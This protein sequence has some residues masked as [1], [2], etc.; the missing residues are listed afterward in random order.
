MAGIRFNVF[1]SNFDYVGSSSTPVGSGAT[2]TEETPTGTIDGSNNIFNV[3]HTPV[4][5]EIDGKLRTEGYGYTYDSGTGDITVDPLIAPVQSILSFWND[6]SSPKTLTREDPSSGAVD[7]VNLDFVF[8]HVPVLIEADGDFR[9]DGFGYTV[10][11]AGPYTVSMDP[12]IP[13]QQ[14]V[15]SFYNA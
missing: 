15:V 8:A 10:S 1:T 13:P 6:T 3:G 14:S 7:G 2:L 11:G 4:F 5:L 12:L 9:V